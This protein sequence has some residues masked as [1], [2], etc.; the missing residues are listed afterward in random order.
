MKK[1]WTGILAVAVSLALTLPIM[2]VNA[3]EETELSRMGSLSETVVDRNQRRIGGDSDV[4]ELGG[5]TI[6]QDAVYPSEDAGV[7]YFVTKEENTPGFMIH[8][9]DAE[10]HTVED[11]AATAS[12]IDDSIDFYYLNDKL[13]YIK[14]EYWVEAGTE[15][16]VYC[17]DLESRETS[18]VLSTYI[19]EDCACCVAADHSERIY[20]GTEFNNKLLVFENGTMSAEGESQE[21]IEDIVGIDDENGNI[22]YCSEYNWVYFGFPH[23]VSGLFVARLHADNTIEFESEYNPLTIQYQKYYYTHYGCASLLGGK[24]LANL[25]TFSEDTLFIV[26][27]QKIAPELVTESETSIGLID[28]DVTVSGVNLEDPGAVV[29]ADYTAPSEYKDHEDVSSIGP[30]CTYDTSEN[31]VLVKK[32]SNLIRK[33]YDL[34]SDGGYGSIT[35]SHPVYYITEK[36]NKLLVLE[37]ENNQFYV[38]QFDT[39]LPVT[40]D[41]TGPSELEAGEVGLYAALF[42]SDLKLNAVFSSSDSS[43]LSIDENGNASAWA[44]GTCTVTATSENGN[45]AAEMTVTVTEK[46][47]PETGNSEISYTGTKSNNKGRNDYI[48]SSSPVRSYLTE[49]DEGLMRVENIEN[50]DFIVE[51]LKEDGN[52]SSSLKIKGELKQFGGFYA[53]EESYYVVF[54]QSNTDESDDREVLRVV[55]YDKNWQRQ[56][57]L[58]ICA[59]N[60][61]NPFGAGSL[62][63]TEYNGTLYIH[64]CHIMYKTDDGLNHQANMTFEIRETDMELLDSYTKVMNL[65]EG[66]VSHSFN[67]FIRSR[68]G[69]IYRVDHGDAYPRGI[70]FTE[71]SAEDGKMSEPDMTAVLVDFPGTP[72]DNYTGVSLGGFEISSTHGLVVYNEDSDFYSNESVRNIKVAVIELPEGK[73][74]QIPITEYSYQDGITCST[75]QMVKLSDGHFLVL[76]MERNMKSGDEKL[77]LAKINNSGNLA[78]NIIRRPGALSDCQPILLKDGSAAWYVTDGNHMKLYYYDPFGTDVKGIALNKKS[79]VLKTKESLELTVDITPANATNQKLIWKSSKPSVASVENGMVKAL[80]YGKTVITVTSLDGGY[81]AQCNVQ[82]RYYDVADSSKYYFKPVYWAADQG[83]TNGYGNVYFGTDENCTREQ[84]ITFL[85]RQAGKPASKLKSVPF[86]DADSS[87][88]YYKAV[89]W[90]YEKGI[91][92]GYSSGEHAGKFGVGLPVT[93]EDT[94][95]FIYRMAGKPSVSNEDLKK[96]TFPDEASG[97]Y[98]CKPIAW[99]AKSGITKGYTSGEYAGMFGVGL[100][101]LRQDIVTFLYRYAGL[102]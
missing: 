40:M 1:K 3:A 45:L 33:Y 102:K 62:R 100:N 75:P 52:V 83:I 2:S 88:Y 8:K 72:G 68:N 28:S 97:A 98:Y 63:M 5:I 69:M 71:Y 17:L 81:Q 74:K 86:S 93:R 31:S 4:D 51:Y 82:T 42:S 27:S 92:K 94:V 66:Y 39:N 90:A 46:Q 26:D 16:N 30:R 87:A 61:Y 22:Y 6:Y 53:G 25:S 70:T 59:I 35:T 7:F 89:L 48:T 78:G 10:S 38:E 96:Y 84:M 91:T 37:K 32:E 77:A 99:A 54:G 85:W 73:T 11:I 76:W 9:Y 57:S 12:E 15:C 23:A 67:Q 36:N 56:D 50:T 95:T 18:I 43:I 58:S 55:K 49:T 34:D 80:T 64:T 14:V 41:I 60:T 20:L 44:P 21:T 47:H 13:Y 101:V 65:S 19:D 29:M 24:Y 79:V